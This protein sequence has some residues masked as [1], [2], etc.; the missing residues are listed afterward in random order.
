MRHG[1]VDGADGLDPEILT[2]PDLQD[3]EERRARRDLFHEYR[4]RQPVFAGLPW[5]DLTWH[6]ATLTEADLRAR[7]FSCRNHF[8]D[9]Y[10]TR[11]IDEIAALGIGRTHRSPAGSRLES[12]EA[13]RWSHRFSSLSLHSTSW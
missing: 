4:G 6:E 8:E 2:D 11:R 10:A 5:H 3:A 7:T 9:T 12:G 13:I 1:Y